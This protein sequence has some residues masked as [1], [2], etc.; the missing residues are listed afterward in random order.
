MAVLL[1]LDAAL[2]CAGQYPYAGLVKCFKQL[3]IISNDV[4]QTCP[5]LF[6]TSLPKF[7]EGVIIEH[8]QLVVPQELFR[9]LPCVS[10]SPR[11]PKRF[12]VRA[13]CCDY[14]APLSTR[15]S[16]WSPLALPSTLVVPFPKSYALAIFLCRGLLCPFCL[17]PLQ[18]YC[19]FE[20]TT[21]DGS[22]EI[23]HIRFRY[24]LIGFQF[25]MELLL[26]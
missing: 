20:G 15:N 16:P 21:C 12:I 11:N 19:N 9:L 23:L 8:H 7:I 2:F 25:C 14:S 26:N 10:N 4:V 24:W 3:H 13:K 22:T 1:A 5:Y 17:Y 18:C 6:G